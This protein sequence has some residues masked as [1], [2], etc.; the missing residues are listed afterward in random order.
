MAREWPRVFPT[1]GSMASEE[2]SSG[3]VCYNKAA[4][5]KRG[6]VRQQRAMIHST[7]KSDTR[8]VVN[9][10]D[11]SVGEISQRSSGNKDLL[12]TE[13]SYFRLIDTS[14]SPGRRCCVTVSREKPSCRYRSGAHCV[15]QDEKI[16]DNYIARS[17][18]SDTTVETISA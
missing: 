4:S 17:S 18:I 9:V 7:A 15:L 12:F 11:V 10:C 2:A 16:L 1:T 8:R 6:E 14:R 13:G 3:R 5:A